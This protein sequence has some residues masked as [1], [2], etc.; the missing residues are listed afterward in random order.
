LLRL[1]SKISQ[2]SALF[3]PKTLFFYSA[4]SPQ[5]NLLLLLCRIRTLGSSITL[6]FA[7]NIKLNLLYASILHRQENLRKI[8]VLMFNAR[9]F[10]IQ[11][12]FHAGF[13]HISLCR[14]FLRLCKYILITAKQHR[15]S[16]RFDSDAALE[17]KHPKQHHNYFGKIL[18]NCQLLKGQAFYS[19][20]PILTAVS[21]AR[22]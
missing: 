13:T 9:F 21:L 7:K 19:S 11:T 5:Y 14:G 6:P 3:P 1:F 4:D 8:Q 15:L 22:P 17:I 2:F 12:G 16:N 10:E 18:K 20:V